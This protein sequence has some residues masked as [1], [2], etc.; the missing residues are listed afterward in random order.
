MILSTDT[1][2]TLTKFNTD[3]D[4]NVYSRH[5]EIGR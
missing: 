5:I 4:N 2:K 3:H 1:G